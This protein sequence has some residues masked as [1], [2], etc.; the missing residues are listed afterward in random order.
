M[1]LRVS[2]MEFMEWACVRQKYG[3]R[4]SACISDMKVLACVCFCSRVHFDGISAK[5]SWQNSISDM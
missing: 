5:E 3:L 1:T 2:I 4:F